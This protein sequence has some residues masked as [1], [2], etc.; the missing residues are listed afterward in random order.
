MSQ[1]GCVG[2]I[3]VAATPSFMSQL[4]LAVVVAATVE[5]VAV[6]ELLR[7]VLAATLVVKV[8]DEVAATSFTGSAWTSV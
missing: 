2:A 5:A 1:A 4:D 6:V 3:V 8:V 7:A